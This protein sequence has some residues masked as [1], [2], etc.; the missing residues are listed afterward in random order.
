MRA[1]RLAAAVSAAAWGYLALL[2]GGF[3]RTD[4]RLPA[5][6]RAEAGRS[7]PSVA[8]VVP[9]RNEAL[10][11]GRTLPTLLAQ[12]Y[13]GPARVLLVDDRSADGTGALAR[14][15]GEDEAGRL[16]LAVVT[17]EP[18]P[19]GWAG[20]PWALQQ[21]VLATGGPDFLLFT[22]ADIA[23]PPDSLTRL[24]RLAEDGR[25]DLVSVMA[26]LR[27]ETGWERLVVPAFV[28]FFAQLYPFRRV[29][30]ASSRTA[31][32]AGGCVLVRRT[33]LERAGGIPA[34]RDAVIDDVALATGV[35]RSGG[36]LW[37][38]LGSEVV[39]LRTYPRL[40]DLWEMVA[41]SADTQLRHSL[42]LLAATV[43]GLVLV[44]LVPPVATAVGLARWQP[45]T[46]LLGGAAWAAMSATYAPMLRE[47]G[48]PV[49]RAPALPVAALLYLAMTLDSARRHRS[50]RAVAWRTTPGR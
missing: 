26:R 39:S 10:L 3:W 31:A 28:Y 37:L 47:Y 19:A 35:A 33:A 41:R 29:A 32:A 9:A 30:S 4:V 25:R 12:R 17:G 49:W 11:L 7:W 42:P 40:G 1:V 18:M 45:E 21:G 34:L 22:D 14:R 27:A 24:V 23:H 13:A 6:P 48:Q 20:K 43:G 36:R 16:P 5:A 46:A 38:G 8:V 15:L 50:G 2:H 44:Y